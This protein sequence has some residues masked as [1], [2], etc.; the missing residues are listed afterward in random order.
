M[1]K[2]QSGQS[3][4]EGSGR[5]KGTSNLKTLILRECLDQVG[6]DIVQ[7]LKNLYPDLDTQTKAKVLLAFLPYLFPKPESVHI[8]RLRTSEMVTED[9][10]LA[11][12]L[13]G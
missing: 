6:F 8:N 2:Y 1:A 4:P 3:K 13:S 10:P 9:N 7:E 12:L 5:K 11:E